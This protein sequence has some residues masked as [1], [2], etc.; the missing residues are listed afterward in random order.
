[1]V[2]WEG[3][4]SFCEIWPD[5]NG[6]SG[7][8]PEEPLV[9]L[10]QAAE[11]LSSPRASVVMSAGAVDALLKARGLTDGSL[12]ARIGEAVKST[13]LTKEMG[14]W[15][16]DVRLDANDQRHAD[17]KAIPPTTEDAKR[18]LEFAKALADILFVLPARVSR[19]KTNAH[20]AAVESGFVSTSSI[21]KAPPPIAPL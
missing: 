11:T 2:A 10:K 4:T 8:I 6:F 12:Y 5:A 18:C 21:S 9:Y 7:D 16:H 1:M 20:K 13:L 19:G 3:N 15:A 14:E 17:V